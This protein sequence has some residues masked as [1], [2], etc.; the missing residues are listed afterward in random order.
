MRISWEWY[1]NIRIFSLKEYHADDIKI[2]QH[3][4]QQKYHVDDI[5]KSKAS[6]K[7]SITKKISLQ[8]IDLIQFNFF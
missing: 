1:Q 6:K 5:L 7:E 4:N 2:F 3:K 8:L